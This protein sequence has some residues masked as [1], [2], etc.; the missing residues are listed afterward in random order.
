MKQPLAK[1]LLEK[2]ELAMD[3]AGYLEHQIINRVTYIIEFWFQTFGAKVTNWYFDEAGEG[4]VGDLI[5]NLNPNSISNI[6]TDCKPHPKGDMVII[7]KHG[8]EYIWES[9]IPI[10]WLFEDFED[11]VT[12]GKKLFEEKELTRKSKKKELSLAK[13]AEDEKLIA[14]AKKKLSPQELAAIRRAL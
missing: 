12:N 8:D 1:D 5:D 10:R 9:E 2:W 11:E 13:K 3:E 7:D 14:E 4:M 6:Y